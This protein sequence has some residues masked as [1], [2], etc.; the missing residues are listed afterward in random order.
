MLPKAVQKNYRLRENTVQAEGKQMIPN[1]LCTQINDS[2]C[3]PELMSSMKNSSTLAPVITT[4]LTV[5]YL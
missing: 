4:V 1:I 2:K 5:R 3:M